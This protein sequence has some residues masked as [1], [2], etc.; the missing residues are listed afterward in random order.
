VLE[1]EAKCRAKG[2]C[3]DSEPAKSKA[4]GFGD[5][6]ERLLYEVDPHCLDWAHCRAGDKAKGDDKGEG[7]G[8]NGLHDPSVAS[9]MKVMED[10]HQPRI[11]RARPTRLTTRTRLRRRDDLPSSESTV[12]MISSAS[13]PESF[14]FW[15][16]ALVDWD[17]L[18]SRSTS[19]GTATKAILASLGAILVPA[20]RAEM[21]PNVRWEKR[22]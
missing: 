21:V 3:D 10:I 11:R 5:A 4:Y 6:E 22:R 8:E 1:L 20:K 2:D 16:E 12:T 14:S 17:D 18:F 15:I 7:P 9:R 13:L 19:V